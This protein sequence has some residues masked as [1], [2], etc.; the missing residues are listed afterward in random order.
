MNIADSS[1]VEFLNSD[2][3][4]TPVWLIRLVC[5]ACA[6]AASLD[7]CRGFYG[8]FGVERLRAI[9]NHWYQAYTDHYEQDFTAEPDR[10]AVDGKNPAQT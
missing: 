4:P 6:G 1:D 7:Q 8:W 10:I 9:V 2:R 3:T 5:A